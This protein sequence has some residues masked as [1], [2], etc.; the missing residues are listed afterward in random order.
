MAKKFLTDINIAGGV[1]DSSGDIGGSGQVLSSTGSGINW[2]DANSAAS[3]VYQDGFTGNG[4]A[5]AFT[6]A[7]S[8][9]NE[10]KTQVY[11]DGVYQ[12][13]DN[14]SLSGTTLTFSTAPPNTSDIEVISFSS[15]SAADDIL[16]DTDFGSAGLMTTNGSGVYSITTNNS[17][18]W[19]TAYTHSQAAHAPA[20]AEQ[21]VQ[22]DW[23]ATSGDS[24]IQN[25][26]TIP[27][28]NQIIDWTADQ[29]STE[30]HS[31]NYINTTYTVGDGGLTQNNFTNAL[32]TKL[33]GIETSADVTDTANVTAAG[34]LMDSEL[35]D[36]AGVKGVTISNLATV[37]YVDTEV[38]GL[39]DSSPATLDTLNELAAALGDDPNFATTTATSI[40]LKAPLASPSF[41]GNASFAENVTIGDNKSIISNGSVRIDID[42]DNNS[43]TRAFVVRNNG[44]ANTLFRVQED[45]YVGIGTASPS[46]K[47]HVSHTTRIDDAY[48]LALV[49]NT[50]TGTGSAA[51]SA[52]NIKSKY[53]TSQFM[54]W[55][56]QGL[57][58]GSRIVANGAPGDV[59]F[60][61]GSDS[62]KM[63]MKAGGNVGIG[64]TSPGSKLEVKTSG[65]NTTLEL[66]NSDTNYTLIQ[67]NA[68]GATKGF[69][70]F[71]AGFML[72]GG[73][74]GTTT[75]LQSG[76]SYAATILENGNFGIGTTSPGNLLDV[77][78]DTDITGQLVVSH[79][80]NYVA[81]FV[82]TATSMSN[83]NYALMVNS[84]SHTSNMTTAGAMAVDVNSGRAF[85][86]NGIG[87][88]S[89][90]GN[91]QSANTLTLTGSATELDLSNT[92]SSGKNY[93]IAST[94]SGALEFIDKAANV[95]RMRIHGDGS[96]G[97]GA[98]PANKLHV[99]AGT[100]NIVAQFQST[101]GTGGIMLKDSSGNVEL[102]TSGTH[103]FNIQ[104]NGGS[105]VFRVDQNGNVGIGTTSPSS[106]YADQLVVKCSSSE[107]GITIA[108]NSTTDANYLMFADGTSGS[109]R[110]RGQIKY[111]HQDNYME[112]ATD[113]SNVMKIDSSG[114]VGINASASLRFNGAGDN[115]HAVGYDSIIDGSF[116]RGQLG[117]RF[118]TGTGGGSERMRITSGGDVLI[119]T[120]G[121]FLQGKRNTGSVVI[122]MIGFG[123]GTDTLQIKGG[124]SGA[125]NA[126]S[127][128][129]TGGF[130][131]TFYNSNF[132]I[133]TNSPSEILQTNKNSAGN[134]VGGYFTNSQ[135][136]TGAESVSLA[137]GLNRSGGDFVRQVKAITFGAEQQWTGTESTVDGY[138]SFSTISNETVAERLRIS[139]GG[140]IQSNNLG[141]GF[142]VGYGFQLSPQ[143]GYS[144][145]YMESN[146]TATR[147]LQRFYNPN[148]NIGNIM[149]S[150]F[151]TTYGTS[152]D[153]RL[154]ENVVEMT[155]ALDRVSQ[156]KPSRFN[157]IGDADKTVD[158][159]LAHEVQEI[160]PEAIT[161]EKDAVDEEGNPDY[162]GI[163]QSK[164]V[165]LL[166]GAIQELKA[167]IETLKLQI[168]N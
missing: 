33:D 116:L 134:I 20:N 77:A 165:P 85:T 44:G 82:N 147:S 94:S 149:I 5:T 29:G 87:R 27:S 112:F 126:I 92:S 79:D 17:S 48:G 4:S 101:D 124:T 13:K 103:G 38:A 16:Y 148:G 162:Q 41:T 26:P 90:G 61:A 3:V 47:L 66:D 122:D 96:V 7:N 153:Y 109:D 59:Y 58:I 30:I 151:T 104:P 98:T 84:S 161:G 131:G 50:S 6:L 167:E 40:G 141:S 42:N 11:I 135:A 80:T 14:Y 19:N 99:N 53:G 37:S 136:N 114:N 154:K 63:V 159:F 78:G 69:S 46:T 127:F 155:D 93:R 81:K 25:K 64:T 110:Y 115:T 160:V 144:Q 54:Q 60:T 129:D 28:G 45:G 74:S 62:V 163:D 21:N 2:I 97:I 8:I 95:E 23:T 86:I 137:F 70:G 31:G 51:N 150:G 138:L 1:Y 88:V 18:N 130:L 71:N 156:L 75:R 57:R 133:G 52:L 125:A 166:V 120:N 105:T 56:N 76:G 121:K 12:H 68:Q 106:Y 15:V 67:Y 108:S 10:N 164:L 146:T 128:Y 100:T 24:F 22:S 107:N 83:D 140:N 168:N 142:T 117:M 139:S 157:F 145:I 9:D 43:T 118:L 111:N 143:P 72:F 65:T 158:G 73:E 123:A 39:V 132:G 36:L 34:A 113:A 35:T 152:S 119:A 49:E 32:K 91:T 55:E 89:I 102:T